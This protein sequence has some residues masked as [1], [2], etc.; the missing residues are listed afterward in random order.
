MSIR[1]TY[2]HHRKIAGFPNLREGQPTKTNLSEWQAAE[3]REGRTP[4]SIPACL[5]VRKVEFVRTRLWPSRLLDLDRSWEELRD[6]YRVHFMDGTY[7]CLTLEHGCPAPQVGRY[8]PRR[9]P[10]TGRMPVDFY[11]VW[12]E[13]YPE[14]DG[15]VTRRT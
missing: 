5:I 7:D 10:P 4:P 13:A 12:D 6:D 1:A 11:S 15:S 3:V 8:C 9:Y 14:G 2:E